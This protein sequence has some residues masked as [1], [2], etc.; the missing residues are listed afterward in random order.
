MVS[1]NRNYSESAAY[2]PMKN[3]PVVVVLEKY[4]IKYFHELMEKDVRCLK[5]VNLIL[6]FL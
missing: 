2:A 5:G 4:L 3:H 1:G 6:K